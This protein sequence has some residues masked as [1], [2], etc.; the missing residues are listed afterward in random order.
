MVCLIHDQHKNA[1][2]TLHLE[3]NL[4]ITLRFQTSNHLP[5]IILHILPDLLIALVPH[6]DEEL[7]LWP[8]YSFQTNS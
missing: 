3:V 5:T 1:E 4:W 6:F 8:Y 7:S 2:E